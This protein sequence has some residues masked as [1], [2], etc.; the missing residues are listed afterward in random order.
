MT[1]PENGGDLEPVVPEQADGPDLEDQTYDNF[2]DALKALGSDDDLPEEEEPDPEEEPESDDEPEEEDD[3][4]EEES[5]A[6]DAIVELPDGETLTLSEIA[7]LKANG[8]RAADYTHKTTEVAREKEAVQALRSQ[9]EQNLQYVETTQQNIAKFVEG[10]IPPEPSLE[11]AQ[12]NPAEYT[13]ARALREAAIAELNKLVS[14]GDDVKGHKATA[15]EADMKAYRDKE[16]AA[17]VKAMPHLKD[18]VKKHAFDEAVSKTAE[19]FGFSPEEIGATADHRI[20]QLVH[21]ARM[22]KRSE[23]NRNNA[24]RRVQTPTKG[25]PKPA[26]APAKTA[27]NRDAMRR[28]SKS[29]SLENGLAVDFA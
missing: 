21:Y 28:L 15:S 22:G 1:T 18:P 6:G 5:D 24:K 8:L 17:L 4:E 16:T 3:P 19:E 13:Q 29:D 12:T 7:D 25:K 14:I 20:L 11:L 23:Q 26:A 10:L 27:Q 9:Y 2:E